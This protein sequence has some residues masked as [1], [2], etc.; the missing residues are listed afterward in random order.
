MT[1]GLSAMAEFLRQGRALA[2]LSVLT[3]GLRV[4]RTSAA[5]S[6]LA[7]L[8]VAGTVGTAV[9]AALAAPVTANGESYITGGLLLSTTGVVLVVSVL[10][11]LWASHIAVRQARTWHPGGD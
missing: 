3:G 2:P 6:V 10:L 11:W 8:A 1:A 4:F 7:P 9:A 5:W